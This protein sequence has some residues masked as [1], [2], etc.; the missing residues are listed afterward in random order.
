MSKVEFSTSEIG[1]INFGAK[2]TD[3]REVIIPNPSGN[4]PAVIMMRHEQ[5]AQD[6]ED[7]PD[8]IEIN[9]TLK[10]TEEQMLEIQRQWEEN[11]SA[12]EE[13]WKL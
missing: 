5:I 2:P 11:D 4:A 1:Q 7:K 8:V 13:K 12:T 10:L 6:I 3:D 9:F